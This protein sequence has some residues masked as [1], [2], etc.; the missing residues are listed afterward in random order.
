MTIADSP[1]RKHLSRRVVVASY[2][3]SVGV[4]LC[5]SY[6]I[7]VAVFL[8]IRMIGAGITSG[9]P[10]YGLLAP[11]LPVYLLLAGLASSMRE[12]HRNAFQPKRT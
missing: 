1:N 8:G 3:I 9:N 12:S 2:A 11:I 6:A 5:L 10:W 7:S 4:F